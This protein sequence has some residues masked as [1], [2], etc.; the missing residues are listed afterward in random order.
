MS[1]IWKNDFDIH[2]EKEKKNMKKTYHSKANQIKEV[3]HTKFQ[4]FELFSNLP[5][6]DNDFAKL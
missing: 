6:T 3:F 1:H 4:N 2:F 5:T